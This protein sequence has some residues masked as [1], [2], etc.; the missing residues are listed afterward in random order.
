MT[1]AER[2]RVLQDGGLRPDIEESWRRSIERGLDPSL[3]L[4]A[5]ARADVDRRSRLAV[6]AGPVLDQLAA[7]FHDTTYCLALADREA[8]IVDR[9]FGRAHMG[10]LMDSVGLVPGS[11]FHELNSG[12]NAIATVAELGRPLTVTGAEHYAD[13]LRG[14]ACHGYPIHDP[15]TAELAGVLDISCPME[16][17]NPLLTALLVRSVRA[18]E[19]RLLDA[20]RTT[21]QRMLD[22]YRVAAQGR[23]RPVLLL[24]ETSVLANAAAMEILDAVDQAAFRELAAA[25]PWCDR[26]RHTLVLASGVRVQVDVT[27]IDAGPQVLF[28]FERVD[29]LDS[30]GRRP[31]A[32]VALESLA[33]SLSRARSRQLAVVVS[34]E[35]GTG[36]TSLARQLAAP[37]LPVVI[38]GTHVAGLGEAAWLARFGQLTRA[39]TLVVIEDVQVLPTD[40]VRR[41]L[42]LL[43]KGRIW[44]ALT[45]TP[46]PAP[47]GEHAVLL[48]RCSVRV[49]L[50]PLRKRLTEL[51]PLVRDLTARL[52]PGAPVRFQPQTLEVLAR[53]PWPGNLRELESVLR[54]VLRNRSS[55]DITPT[56][57]PLEYRGGV[58]ARH[59]TTVQQLEHDAIIAALDACRGNKVKAAA[60]LGMSRST[61]Y[62][63]IR[64]LGVPDHD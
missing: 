23:V 45:T 18:I 26:R 9:R 2:L 12:T 35:P 37:A 63:R 64:T 56:D 16:Q 11:D 4:S 62:R 58:R 21:D 34:G 32:P 52:A 19:E 38:E 28:E 61:L 57:L 48:A 3:D 47:S 36:R 17:D 14:Y 31:G 20:A 25:A 41:L 40:T 1:A 39:G 15:V 27:R 8:R 42:P 54:N 30:A 50:P 22:V 55:G 60:R 6:A 43:D 10:T 53:H 51:G 59:L 5:V 29:D 49:N 7:E 33:D 46:A 13:A 44:F 24:G